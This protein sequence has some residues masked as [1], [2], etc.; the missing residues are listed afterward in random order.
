MGCPVCAH[1]VSTRRADA[2]GSHRL[3]WRFWWQV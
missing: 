3:W 1:R 2:F